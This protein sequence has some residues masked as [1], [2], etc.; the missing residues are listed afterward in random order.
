M[1][2]EERASVYAIER[3]GED[4]KYQGARGERGAQYA[5]RERATSY[6]MNLPSFPRIPVSFPLE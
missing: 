2:S 5:E 6:D 3:E 4:P 1:E